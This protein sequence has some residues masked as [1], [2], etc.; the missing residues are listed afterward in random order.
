LHP[1]LAAMIAYAGQRGAATMIPSNGTLLSRGKMAQEIVHAGLDT[2]KISIDAAT[3]QTYQAIRRQDC[4]ARI[5]EGI[6]ELERIKQQDHSRRPELRLD[7]VILQENYAEIPD[8]V[9]LA[10]RLHIGTVFFRALQ[11]TGLRGAREESIGKDV[12]FESLYKAVREGIARA[13]R[14][15]VRTNLKEVARD[16]DAYQSIYVHQD[17]A[18][19]RH[20]CLLPWVQCFLSVRG[21]LSPCCATYTNAGFSAGNVLA[22]GFD[23]VWNGPRMQMI[24]RQFRQHRNPLAVCRDCLPRSLPVLLEMSSMLP[25]FVFRR[26]SSRRTGPGRSA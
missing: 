12:D 15:A 22:D 25:G 24:R 9:E 19:D 2:L 17:A 21:E 14:L 4:F 26:R 5:V 8:I 23:A 7:V 13:V 3:P 10:H 6:R 16:F 11:A 1:D 20:A 18:L